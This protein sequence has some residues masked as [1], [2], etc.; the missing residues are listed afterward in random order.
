MRARTVSKKRLKLS[1]RWKIRDSA[2][3]KLS[4]SARGRPMESTGEVKTEMEN[5]DLSQR[6]IISD[7][8]I[9]RQTGIKFF[10]AK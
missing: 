6:E 8:Q 7:R 2:T 5:Q 3:G 1:K 10:G 9:D 4:D